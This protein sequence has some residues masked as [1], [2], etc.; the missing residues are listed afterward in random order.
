MIARVVSSVTA[1]EELI[2][3]INKRITVCVCVCV[4]VSIETEP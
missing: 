4:C 3:N 2:F 1:V